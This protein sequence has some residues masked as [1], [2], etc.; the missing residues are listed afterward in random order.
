MEH[1]CEYEDVTF[2]SFAVVRDPGAPVAEFFWTCYSFSFWTSCQL[3]VHI[4]SEENF[5]HM[6]PRTR[7]P[8]HC[9]NQFLGHPL[10]DQI[11]YSPRMVH[12]S[13][14]LGIE[15]PIPESVSQFAPDL[16]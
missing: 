14:A 2:R 13:H 8:H 10:L 9:N 3:A 4:R 16:G 15:P 5:V 12:L 7:P 6:N 1:G 11:G